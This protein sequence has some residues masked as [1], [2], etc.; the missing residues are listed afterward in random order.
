[1][2]EQPEE[3]KPGDKESD[4]K[5]R[6][7]YSGQEEIQDGEEN[8][9]ED[10]EEGEEEEDGQEEKDRSEDELEWKEEEEDKEKKVITKVFDIVVIKISC[11]VCGGYMCH[12]H[13]SSAVTALLPLTL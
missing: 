1:M 7:V 2:Q 3:E 9:D 12:E 11:Y 8:G 5:E 4:R 10:E 13:C 6:E